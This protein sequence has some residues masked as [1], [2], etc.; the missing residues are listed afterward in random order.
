MQKHA[1]IQVQQFAACKQKLFPSVWLTNRLL[2]AAD[3]TDDEGFLYN[4]GCKKNA[5]KKVFQCTRHGI[6]VLLCISKSRYRV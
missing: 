3:D 1:T 6:L 2:D 4:N 5:Q